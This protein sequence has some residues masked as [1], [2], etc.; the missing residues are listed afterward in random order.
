MKQNAEKNAPGDTASGE[1]CLTLEATRFMTAPKGNARDAAKT[2]NEPWETCKDG[3]TVFIRVA[4]DDEISAIS[5]KKKNRLAQILD[6]RSRSTPAS[7]AA[8]NNG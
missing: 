1:G 4:E 3:H 6:E 7:R 5:D 8:S 2:L